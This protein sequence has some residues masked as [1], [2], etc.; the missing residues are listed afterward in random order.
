MTKNPN[1]GS[2]TTPAR[3]R[4]IEDCRHGRIDSDEMRRR[5]KEVDPPPGKLLDPLAFAYF[6][7]LF[8]KAQTP[9]EWEA[10]GG[11]WEPQAHVV[12]N[13]KDD[14]HFPQVTACLKRHAEGVVAFRI[15]P[16][17][18]GDV[19][20]IELQFGT[21]EQWS[22]FRKAYGKV[23]RHKPKPKGMNGGGRPRLLNE[24]MYVLP[25]G[26]EFWLYGKWD[27]SRRIG[28]VLGSA[29]GT[30][31]NCIIDE[32]VLRQCPV[33]PAGEEPWRPC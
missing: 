14:Y 33:L 28:K 7:G 12:T 11:R 17:L 8:D 1:L 19:L 16:T 24:R 21:A 3:E 32:H 4:I 13:V 20:S 18:G 31:E 29:P 5:L 15:T 9:D 30:V 2:E 23:R 27:R 25:D 26:R 6:P 22:A 10:G